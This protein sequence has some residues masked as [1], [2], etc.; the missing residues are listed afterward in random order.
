MM[1]PVLFLMIIICL[2]G[3]A[4][5]RSLEESFEKC[6]NE[7]GV[8]SWGYYDGEIKATCRNAKEIRSGGQNEQ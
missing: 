3:C 5:S 4:S 6:R 8:L 7:K 2:V 1:K